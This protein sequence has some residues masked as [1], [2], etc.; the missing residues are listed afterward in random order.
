MRMFD[1]FV[2][3]FPRFHVTACKGAP[4]DQGFHLGRLVH[5]LG[6]G[7]LIVYSVID[8]LQVHISAHANIDTSVLF[9]K[10]FTDSEALNKIF[11][12][13]EAVGPS[14]CPPACPR[15]LPA[16]APARLRHR[17][18]EYPHSEVTVTGICL[19]NIPIFISY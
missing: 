13:S 1:D 5:P 15:A 4:G 16:P 2:A 14:A 17:C 18:Q 9:N 10:L 3:S 12:D 6:P 7:A 8:D 11:T 19:T